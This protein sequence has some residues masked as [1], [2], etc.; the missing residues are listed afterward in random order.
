MRETERLVHGCAN[1]AK[2]AARA[3]GEAARD[4]DTARLENELA[5]AL[6]AKVRIEPGRKG[7]GR[8]VDPLLEPRAARRHR[9][10]AAL[11]TDPR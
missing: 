3:H 1:P 7:A 11:T 10:E 6:G 9:R 5:E 2:R 4:A 8:V